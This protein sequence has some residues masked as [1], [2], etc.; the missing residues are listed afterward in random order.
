[1][2]LPI[3]AQDT[4][5][6]L[7]LA[8]MHFVSPCTPASPDLGCFCGHPWQAKYQTTGYAQW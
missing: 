7:S 6:E 2:I 4:P 8:P 1:M 5:S 3:I